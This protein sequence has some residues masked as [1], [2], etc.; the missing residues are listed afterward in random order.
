MHHVA[1]IFDND[2]PAIGD[3]FKTLLF[4]RALGLMALL[5]LDGKDRT[6][7]APEKLQSL[8]GIKRLWRSG[9]VQGIELPYPFAVCRLLHAGARQVER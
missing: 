7:D 5:S 6:L 2:V 3:C 4:V 9:A 8:L 1:G